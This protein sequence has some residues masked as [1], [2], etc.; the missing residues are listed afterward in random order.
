MR[1]QPVLLSLLCNCLLAQGVSSSTARRIVKATSLPAT[2]TVGDVYFKTATTVGTYQCIATNTWSVMS[3]GSGSGDVLGAAGLTHAN[4]VTCVSSAGTIGE[5]STGTI[6]TAISINGTTGVM[7]GK[8]L[9]LQQSASDVI[10][11]IENEG[12]EI[13]NVNT[14]N[15]EV[16]APAYKAKF[17]YGMGPGDS[18]TSADVSLER[19]GAGKWVMTDTFGSFALLQFGG[20]TSSYPALKRSS[21]KIQVRLADDSNPGT[22]ESKYNSSDGTAGVSGST[23]SAWKDGLCTAN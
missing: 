22:I 9:A 3:T 21:A 23:C 15:N 2:C 13:F 19:S 7:S 12:E 17:F 4:A 14:I 8:K 5:C 11:V 10:H 6:G 16:T 1:L 18:S 20:T